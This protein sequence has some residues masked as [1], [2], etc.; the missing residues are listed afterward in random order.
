[1]EQLGKDT[2]PRLCGAR[3]CKARQAQHS[4]TSPALSQPHTK[5]SVGIN[6]SQPLTCT[7]QISPSRRFWLCASQAGAKPPLTLEKSSSSLHRGWRLLRGSNLCPHHQAGGAHQEQGR[8][9]K[10]E[11]ASHSQVWQEMCS[12]PAASTALNTARVSSE[13]L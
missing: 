3:L 11:Q 6:N 8:E 4:G 2:L 1:M 12:S 7:P 13:H 10:N 5:A 9:V